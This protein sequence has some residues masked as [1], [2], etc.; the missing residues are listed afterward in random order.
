MSLASPASVTGKTA[1]AFLPVILLPPPAT[2]CCHPAV[3]RKWRL[4]PRSPEP[5]WE[6]R[7]AVADGGR[8][9]DW[10][11][12]GQRTRRYRQPRWAHSQDH[13]KIPSPITFW[14]PPLP[15]FKGYF[16]S[17]VF[18]ELTNLEGPWKRKGLCWIAFH[19]PEEMR[20]GFPCNPIFRAYYYRALGRFASCQAELGL[21]S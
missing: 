21:T 4:S 9:R 10:I 16:I 11:I 12:E 3:S 5:V 14:W 13:I 8:L 15:G 6:M 19:L 17:S 2:F 18:R 7:C 1:I 20:D